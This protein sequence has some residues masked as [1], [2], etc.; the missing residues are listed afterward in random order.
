LGKGGLDFVLALTVGLLIFL[1]VD[2][3]AEGLE[4]AETIPRSYQPTVL[5]AFAAGAS[6]LA[7][8][9]LGRWLRRRRA[10]RG[11]SANTGWILALLVAIGIGLH[12]FGEGL[13][14]AAAFALGEAALGSLLIIGFTLHNTTE[15]L[16]MVA[17]LAHRTAEGPARVPLGALVRLGLIGGVP[18]I[19]GA[20]LGGFVY[21]PVWALLCL[22]LGV[23]AI[24][25]VVIQVLGQMAGDE[26]LVSY[27]AS[28][29]MM[30]GLFTGFIVM[31]ATGMLIG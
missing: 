17:P 21:S 1:M 5:F 10:G 23:G 2:A 14:I 25:Q 16:A 12:N 31:Y 11:E 13:A 8:A 3:T 24:A 7:L 20:W 30:A 29:P 26:P 18:T 27:M 28:G 22:A 9:G 6:Y 4:A 15:G 19:A